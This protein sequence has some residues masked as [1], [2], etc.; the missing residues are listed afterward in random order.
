MQT[1]PGA[2]EINFESPCQFYCVVCISY[3]LSTGYW[4]YGFLERLGLYK[5]MGV[6]IPLYFLVCFIAL[7][8]AKLLSTI[9]F[10]ILPDSAEK[11]CSVKND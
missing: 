5:A 9:S 8:L 10:Y 4:P 2:F 6:L 3:N 1:K 11:Q 7:C